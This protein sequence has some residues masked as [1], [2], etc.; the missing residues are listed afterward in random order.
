[1]FDCLGWFWLLPTI[2]QDHARIQ[3]EISRH[4]PDRQAGAHP[5]LPCRKK[6]A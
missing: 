6:K 5:P 3:K 1:M 4:A 2:L